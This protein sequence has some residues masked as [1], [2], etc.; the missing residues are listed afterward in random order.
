MTSIRQPPPAAEPATVPQRSFDPSTRMRRQAM[1]M[2]AANV[3]MR[4]LLSLPFPTPLSGRLMLLTV[5]GRRTGKV[6]RQPI[7]YVRSGEDLLTPGGGRWKLN[8]EPGR[9]VSL[10][11]R[12]KDRPAIPTVIDELGEVERLLTIIVTTNPAA[13]KFMPI[14][15]DESG[16]LDMETLKLAVGHGFRIITWHLGE[17]RSS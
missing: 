10:R 2:N 11:I 6:Y 5:T 12:G 8:L 13:G 4:R 16:R 1:V 3:V 17:A 14:S 7:S 9:P 15:V